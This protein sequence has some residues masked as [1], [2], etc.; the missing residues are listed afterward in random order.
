MF[1]EL[2]NTRPLRIWID[3]GLNWVVKHWGDAFEA[4]AYPLLVMLNTIERF[5]LMV[6]GG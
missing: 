6:L 2:F 3:D 1:P 5:L 4:A